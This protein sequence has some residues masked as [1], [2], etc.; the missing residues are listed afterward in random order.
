MKVLHIISGLKS[1]GAEGVMYRLIEKD[2]TNNHYVI[3]LTDDGFYGQRFKKKNIF[4]KC[5]HIKKGIGSFFGV[6]RKGGYYR[7]R[8]LPQYKPPFGRSCLI[9]KQ[10][11]LY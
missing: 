8:F 6:I 9:L 10:I 5:L 4:L 11:Y 1:G 3:S 2:T 7:W